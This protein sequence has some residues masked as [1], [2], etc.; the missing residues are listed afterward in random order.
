MKFV[1]LTGQQRQAFDEE[2]FLV[3]PN[4]LD[5]DTMG[6]LVQ[7]GDKLMAQFLK[8]DGEAYCQR[9]DSI[10]KEKIFRDM[11]SYSRTVPL[12]VQLL[13]PQIHLHTSS[14]IY[15]R[16]GPPSNERAWHRDIGIQQDLG[17]IG[18]P[19]VGVKICYCLT[20]FHE[21]ESGMTL[22]AR[23]S[24][25]CQQALQIP[26][27]ACDPIEKVDPIL[28]AGDAILFENRTFHTAASNLS[29]RISKVLI[30]GYSYR[31]MRPDINL[32][33]LD[34]A[35]P[36]VRDL[37]EIDKQLLGADGYHDLLKPAEALLE[38]AGLHGVNAVAD[39]S[40]IAT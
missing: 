6:R 19:R 24:H 27:G 23:G 11:I 31:W 33:L 22:F 17:H 7:T 28:N 40:E 16:P 9:R 2:G 36:W 38:W 29:D 32:D 5:A 8:G 13:T 25:K 26:P 35:A 39:Y 12:V 1:E 15:K 37:S 21:S 14:L 4:V 18:L 34:T 3:V 10:V 30:N 20:D